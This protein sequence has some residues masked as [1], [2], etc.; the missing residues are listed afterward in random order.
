LDNYL[1]VSSVEGTQAVVLPGLG[2]SYAIRDYLSVFAGLH[3]GFAPVA[4][5][6]PAAVDPE[7]SL[8]VEARLRA[9]HEGPRLVAAP[10]GFYNDYTNLLLTCAASAGCADALI[11]QQFNAG[12]ANIGGIEATFAKAFDLG[13]SISV[14]VRAAYTFTHARLRH[15]RGAISAPPDFAGAVDG[16]FVPYIPAHQASADLGLDWKKLG[17]RATGTYFG[18]M[19]EQAGQRGEVLETDDYFMLDL[20]GQ[21]QML[22]RALIYVRFENVTNA[23]PLAAR[24]PFGARPARPFQAQVGLKVD[25]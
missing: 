14:P 17:F 10:S 9:R 12:S 25:L 21:Y 4:P 11:G 5:G 1:T 2:A 8:S 23:Q 20:V 6:Q 18:H 3:R 7:R 16:D 24:R 15:V 19:L 13:R 22:E